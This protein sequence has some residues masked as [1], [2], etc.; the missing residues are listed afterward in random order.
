MG[1]NQKTAKIFFLRISSLIP[2]FKDYN[3]KENLRIN[4]YEIRKFCSKTVDDKKDEYNDLKKK[5]IEEKQHD[6]I[7]KLD[8]SQTILRNFSDKL[9]LSKH[10]YSAVFDKGDEVDQEKLQQVVENDKKLIDLAEKLSD[11]TQSLEINRI[12]ESTDSVINEMKATL[13][14]REELLR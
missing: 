6:L 4:D 1:S 10:G 3:S 8:K 9:R 11:D 7:L 5:A 13:R 12:I 2:G 14:N